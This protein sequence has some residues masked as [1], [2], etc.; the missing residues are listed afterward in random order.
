MRFHREPLASSVDENEGGEEEMIKTIQ[1]MDTTLRDGLQSF[2]VHL[3]V[4]ER[5]Q[6]AEFLLRRVRVDSLE[7]ASARVGGDEHETLTTIVKWAASHHCLERIEALGFIDG[8]SSVEWI[9]SAGCRT[10]NILAKG[11]ERHCRKQ[12]HWTLNDQVEYLGVEV[13]AARSRG[14]AVNVYLE[15]WSQGMRQSP[16]FVSA[17]ALQLA[18]L[19]I[20]RVMLC[21]TLGVLYPLEVRRYVQVV[22]TLLPRQKLDFHGHNDRGLATANTLL[23]IEGGVDG[24]H[25]AVNGMGERAGNTPLEEVVVNIKDF[26]G[27]AGFLVN[28]DE[29]QLTVASRMVAAFSA[30]RVPPNKPIVGA[31]VFSQTAGVHIDGDVKDELYVSD[32]RPE[33]FG[34]QVTHVLGHLG[35]KAS[36]KSNAKKL[37]LDLS[38]EELELVTEKVQELGANHS[39]SP[40]DLLAI[41]AD[42]LDRPE[43]VTISLVKVV[44]NSVFAKSASANAVIA[45]NGKHYAITARGGGGFD[46]FWNALRK[47]A[48]GYGV[49]VIPEL[50][51]Y[52]IDVPTSGD[53]SA[54]TTVIITWRIPDKSEFITTGLDRDQVMAGIK[55]AVAAVNLASHRKGKQS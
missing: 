10:I 55:A 50:V 23:A 30:R 39:L 36:V 3:S 1:I 21:D 40:S 22:R 19:P 45:H 53:S 13:E 42:I 32:L 48:R 29:S 12:L 2:G 17:F 11:S 18:K 28:I 16:E 31:N 35:G 49:I 54:L 20:E 7:V 6:V 34:A 24:V 15:D 27:H 44:T 5:Q 33:R 14:M 8:T 9:A 47:W 43:L 52:D 26:L 38:V 46:A 4:P 25:V 41:V 37:G 51:H